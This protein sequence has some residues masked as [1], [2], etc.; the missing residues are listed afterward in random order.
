M[1][2]DWH[3]L[4]RRKGNKPVFVGGKDGVVI[5]KAKSNPVSTKIKKYVERKID[6]NTE[7]KITQ[8]RKAVTAVDQTATY[9]LMN[10]LVQGNSQ[11]TRIGN[12]IKMKY[13]NIHL[14]LFILSAGLAAATTGY[15][16]RYMVVY[17]RQPNGANPSLNQLLYNVAPT[18]TYES[19]ININGRK[20]YQILTDRVIP[21]QIHGGAT[22]VSNMIYVNR[23][24]KLKGKK[25]VF[26]A[27]NT[28]TITDFVTGSLFLILMCDDF[29]GYTLQTELRY[30]DA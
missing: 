2:K 28:G 21:I 26:N 25:A 7:D 11:I 10:G 8:V 15:Y 13:L 3:S 19:L 14:S 23:R 16:L 6:A 22:N 9:E 12:T 24:I 30:E 27:G 5:K 29:I 18:E 20:R 4:T 1:S 17:D